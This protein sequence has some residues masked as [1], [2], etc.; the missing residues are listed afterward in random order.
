MQAGGR[1][2][3]GFKKIRTFDG[4]D[5]A[6]TGQFVLTQTTYNQSFPYIGTPLST[7]KLVNTGALT[8]GSATLDSCASNGPESSPACIGHSSWPT[9]G[10]TV[11][12]S[13]SQMACIGAGC[14]AISATTC[15]SPT[16]VTVFTEPPAFVPQ[17]PLQPIFTF[18]QATSDALYDL[19]S[20]SATGTTSNYFCYEAGYANLTH[21]TT[22]TQDG[23]GNTVAQKF[24]ANSFYNDTN[25][26]LLG[27]MYQSVVQFAR[28]GLPSI[29]RSTNFCYD[30]SANVTNGLLSACS[31]V[32]PAWTNSGLLI[33]ERMQSGI[34]TDNVDLRTIYTLDAYGNRVAA[35]QCSSDLT[36]AQCTSA[37][38]ATQQQ[39]GITVHRYAKTAYDSLGR[40]STSSAL[41][42]FSSG[43]PLNVNEQVALTINSR[44]EFGNS[45]QQTSI[46]GLVQFTEAGQLGRPYFAKDNTGKATTT[47]FR[48]CTA[49]SCPADAKFRSQTVIAG[50]PSNWT[51][52]DVLGRPIMKLTQA[53][54]AN[55]A[56][57]AFSAVCSYYD[58]HNRP[59]YQSEPFFPPASELA[60]GSPSFNNTAPCNS[61][62]YATSTTFDVLGR[63]TQANNPDGG[64]VY[65]TYSGLTT[66]TSSPR[67]SA[68]QYLE[69]RDPLGETVTTQD[70]T[71]AS[72]PSVG[73]LVRTYYDAAGDLVRIQRS[74]TTSFIVNSMTYD[75]L[76][77]K[78][79]Q[80][81]PDAGNLT[82]VFNA[83]GDLISQTDAK[84]QV[85]TQA[86]DSIGR[87]WQRSTSGAYDGNNIT[88]T[89]TYD[90]AT[91]GYGA[92]A[93]EVRS[94]AAGSTFSRALTYDG[95]GRLYQRTTSIAGYMYT[96]TSAFD[97]YGRIA[98]QQDASGYSLMPEY[99]PT[100]FVG[101][102]YD[103]RA[104]SIYQVFGTNP[105]GQVT[106]DQRGG[107]NA[108]A[109][110]IVYDPA[111][112]RISTICTGSSSTANCTLQDLLYQFDLSGNLT[113]R[114]R[115]VSTA[116]TIEIFTND[117]A[118][119]LKAAVLTE[120]QGLTQNISTASLTYDL[121][122]NICT[123]NGTAYGYS[124]PA[125]C[126]TH[127]SIGSPH[128]VTS[129]GATS[130]GYDANGNQT[131]GGGRT[132][133]YN[134]LN[135]L[136]SASSTSTSTTFQYSPEGERVIR[137]DSTG[138]TTHYVGNVE[139]LR[140]A[141]TETRRYLASVAI[142]YVRSSGTNET[143]YVFSD[144]LGSLDVV[145]DANGAV[146]ETA[147][148][149]VHGALRNPTTWQG[150]G[151][152]PTS[153]NTGFTGHEEMYPLGITHMNGRVYD[154]A[155]GRMLQADP[156][157]GPGNQSL[158]RYS[159]VVNNPLALTD[160][161]GYSWWSDVLKDVV[162]IAILVEAPYLAPY[163]GES[164]IAS[165]AVAGFAAGALETGTLQGG[166]YGAFSA[167]F[168]YGIG[169][170]FDN[171]E[172][173]HVDGTIGSTNLNVAGFSGKILA[174]GLA[175]GVMS[176]LQGGKFGSGFASAGVSEA[177]APYVDGLDPANR[178]GESVSA[179]RV[180]ASALVGGTVSTIS[181]GKFGN[182]AITAAFGRAFNEESIWQ[183]T[184][185][186]ASN[187]WADYI[188]PGLEN[189]ARAALAEGRAAAGFG[190]LVL[191]DALSDTA[192]GA[193]IGIPLMAY[194]AA[195]IAGAA[196]DYSNIFGYQNNWNF[197]ERGYSHLSVAA[198]G[199]DYGPQ[200]FLAT[201]T[202]FNG[203]NYLRAVPVIYNVA[204]PLLEGSG[205]R[206]FINV[207]PLPAVANDAAQAASGLSD[208]NGGH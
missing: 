76:G 22:V 71:D 156:L 174:H 122:G 101:K 206:A 149:D 67:N 169:S 26:W 144:H 92:I 83:A 74:S 173:A 140:S 170:Y 167:E 47:T 82:F 177:A 53:Y 37:T 63:V 10:A 114:E 191:G 132:L 97:A 8:L 137:V 43:A 124:G 50:A 150:A 36:D 141:T 80:S 90:T 30:L 93:N 78:K 183:Q 190:E 127:A 160:P 89:W 146:K 139:I 208:A 45:T 198:T 138:V 193:P 151:A 153:T 109:G 116:P 189:G 5:E 64:V 181:G 91:N 60:D 187:T 34:A 154:P 158:N 147:S 33:E 152:V 194:G 120:V 9:G 112:G 20:G 176:S 39:S 18:T 12:L 66:L 13:Q 175:G 102:Q 96:E 188:Q 155:L 57:Q 179:T 172:W 106:S 168:F 6:V 171:A 199:Y 203:Y 105:R 157:V 7:V 19:A 62:S 192:V 103:T 115:A 38:G 195:N 110:T 200:I 14:P 166:V 197:I 27:R 178:I 162:A 87:R 75:S 41:P 123:K 196:S 94:L 104:G 68:W 28:P 159:Y 51:Y 58:A 29:T 201:D 161:S 21:S 52:Y 135:Q 2:F 163:L 202:L 113:R 204:P 118:N 15:S 165:Y 65:K 134:A 142:D 143:R 126:P 117:A 79:T 85:V 130:Y 24:T 70:P 42:F 133:S 72:D 77:R 129:V 17:G 136:T 128:A 31:S 44:D 73:L 81:D 16:G 182:G 148:F 131:S 48:L 205:Y 184:K 100:G 23:A 95:F 11:S 185:A 88:D 49:V 98:A 1:G 125:G 107:R 35:Y 145:T 119:R 32:Q 86:Y 108:M 46:N 207:A 59:S 69:E 4:N 40:Y 54:D 61:A 55:P 84:N 25:S 164:L 121:L 56:T 180:V 186:A 99:T 111:T 3:L